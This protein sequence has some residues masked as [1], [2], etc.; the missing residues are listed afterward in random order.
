MPHVVKS[1]GSTQKSLYNARDLSV[2]RAH[3]SKNPVLLS[4][5]TP[6]LESMKTTILKKYTYVPIKIDLLAK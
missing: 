1:D 6:S 5:A 2:L 3:L 4:S